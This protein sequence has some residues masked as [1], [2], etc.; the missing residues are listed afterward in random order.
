MKQIFPIINRAGLWLSVWWVVAIVWIVLFFSNV[1]YSIQFTW[2]IEAVVDAE[3]IDQSVADTLQETLIAEWYAIESVGIG[4][5]ESYPSLLMQLALQWDEQVEKITWL[6]ESTLTDAN[7]IAWADDIL[8]LSIIWPSIGE[9]IKKSAKTA[10]IAGTILMAVYILFAFSSMRSLVSPVL[11]G[12]VTIVTMVFDVALPAGAFGLLMWLNPAIQ[13]DTVFIIAL[14]TVMW[15]SVNDTI[16]IFDRIRE[17]FLEKS[18]QMD[19]GKITVEQVFELSLWQ[20]MRRSIWTSLSTFLVVAA[21][22]VFGT[23][24][25]KTF[26]FVL[27][28]WVVA[29]TYS[30]IFLAAP[31]A[32]LLASKKLAQ[33]D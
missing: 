8:E 22:Y 4:K 28:I 20:T 16:V 33:K 13:V 11:L 18:T 9:Y 32:Y 31:F 30:S 25:L 21:M 3:Q 27:W 6:L 14:L 15:Y 10:L 7:V 5:K 29:G 19:K 12:M 26:A 17:N 2:G 23:W 1:R 24:V